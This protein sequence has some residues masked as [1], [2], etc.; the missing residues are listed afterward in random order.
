MSKIIIA[1]WKMKLNINESLE[2]AKSYI[3]EIKTKDKE[4]VICPSE[5]VLSQIKN[6]IKD[7]SIKLGAQNVFWEELG[8]YTGEISA[9]I[10]EEVGCSYTIIG[11]SERRHYLLENYEMIHQKL[12]AVLNHSTLTPV[13]CI[14][15]TLKEKEAGK[16]EF[17]IVDQLQQTL[18]G[19]QLSTDQK[20]IIAYEPIW[21]IG[22]GQ[23][24][25]PEDA[26]NMHE[27]IHAALVDLFGIDIVKKQMK[28]IYG[29]SVN[30][31]N[32]KN[33]TGLANIDGFLIGGAS[34]E[35]EKFLTIIQS[36]TNISI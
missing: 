25:K 20:I 36:I 4:I 26:E 19:V 10:L 35:I 22:T 6:I 16:R 13:I 8:S 3:S 34:L 12:K 33:F 28:I 24:I 30:E 32:I 14:G 2:L 17:V 11:H 9:N 18:S 27:I 23:V 7:S 15:E 29:G 31:S 1:N 5:I 21:A